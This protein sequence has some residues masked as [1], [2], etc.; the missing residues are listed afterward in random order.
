[1]R[2]RTNLLRTSIKSFGVRRIKLLV[3]GVNDGCRRRRT[4]HPPSFSRES[5]HFSTPQTKPLLNKTRAPRSVLIR[6]PIHL[7]DDARSSAS[8]AFFHYARP[9]RSTSSA[10][11]LI[12]SAARNKRNCCSR[13]SVWCQHGERRRLLFFLSILISAR[14]PPERHL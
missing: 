3:A 11:L 2:D 1:M 4:T 9:Q 13:C 5:N 6:A 10:C 14:M 7:R 8:F 12:N